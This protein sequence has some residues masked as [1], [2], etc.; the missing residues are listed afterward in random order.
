[1]EPTPAPVLVEPYHV[2]V[3]RTGG[4]YIGDPYYIRRDNVSGYKDLRV[5]LTV[6][7]LWLTKAY[8]WHNRH[9]GT[10]AYYP[11]IA[12][13]G[14][15]YAFVFVRLEM[16]GE[17]QNF[18]PRMWGFD[19]GNFR[20]QYDAPDGVF[21]LDESPGHQKCVAI[22]ELEDMGTMNDDTRITDYGYTYQYQFNAADD[23]QCMP[24]GFLK[25]GK[26]NAWDG[27]IIYEVPV[28]ATPDRLKLLSSLGGFG[29]PYWVLEKPKQ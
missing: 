9:M 11:E 19:S 15:Q 25:M 14:W 6:Y 8:T 28:N 16:Q 3:K 7:D 27:Y 1:M 10:L 4:K 20:L 2:T 21:I 22:K 12:P 24:D 23:T 17:G 26:S 13:H 5:D 18:D 29:N